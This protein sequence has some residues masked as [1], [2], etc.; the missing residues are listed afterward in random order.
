F[1]NGHLLGTANLSSGSTAVVVAGLPAGSNSITASYS[2]DAT[3]LPSTSPALNQTV[4]K[5]ATST[6]LA[7]SRNP[8]VSGQ[9]VTFTANVMG[10]AGTPT[11]SVEFFDYARSL[12]VIG[13][14]AGS[15]SLT[16]A[17][18]AAGSHSIR[19]VYN[20][21]AKY[22]GRTSPALIQT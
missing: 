11:G 3:H 6:S 4:N 13:L 2:G 17:G 16:T 7:S 8:S 15:A 14:S 5:L 1:D 21:D 12:G 19:A 10:G 20:S 9:A 18:L 22:L